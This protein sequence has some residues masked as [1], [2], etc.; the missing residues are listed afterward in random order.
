[1]LLVQVGIGF[2]FGLH[3]ALWG[4]ATAALV[5]GLGAVQ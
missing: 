2:G 4:G 1:M 3:Y 5:N